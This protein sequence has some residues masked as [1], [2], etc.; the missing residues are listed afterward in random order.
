MQKKK[1]EKKKMYEYL[2]LVKNLKKQWKMTVS[3]T[4]ILVGALGIVN[5][6]LEDRN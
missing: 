2:D 4:P 6:G 1:S 5:R 3:V